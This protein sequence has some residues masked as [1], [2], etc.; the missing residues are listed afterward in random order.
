MAMLVCSIN[1]VAFAETIATDRAINVVANYSERYADEEVEI[2]IVIEGNDLAN[3]Q[4]ELTYDPTHFELMDTDVVADNGTIIDYDFKQ[5][6]TYADG[7]VIRTYTFKALA[8]PVETVS[9][10]GI[11]NTR[12]YTYMESIDAE[13]FLADN[14]ICEYVTIKLRDYIV[15]VKVDGVDQTSDEV[16][17]SYDDKEHTFEVI[18]VPTASVSYKVNGEDVT[19]V[20]IKEEGT[21]TIS[22]T[23]T[24]EL[25]Y[26]P[27]EKSFTV[28]IEKPVYEV[29]VAIGDAMD[30]KDYVSGKKIVLVYT[31]TDNVTFAYDGNAMID[32]SESAYKYNG[33]DYKH[34]YAF[35]TD[36]ISGATVDDYKAKVVHSYELV[37]EKLDAYNAD[38]NLDNAYDIQDVTVGFGIYNVYDG[39]YSNV[40][41]QKNILKADTNN[42]K[43]VNDDDTSN[44]VRD[45][46]FP[47]N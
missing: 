47:Q 11:S 30:A 4:W 40:K 39:Y 7:E 21:Y 15:A 34:V 23:V 18:T 2:S 24:P 32:V 35:V 5:N 14:N 27:I 6:G 12:A 42:D 3:A 22:Y 46:F 17:F 44:I 26:A 29:E 38:L 43:C 13:K 28:V 16:S 8:Q 25:G 9:A 1:L 41:Y 36:A 20:V 10:F 19:S 37:C 33:T 31:D 45:V